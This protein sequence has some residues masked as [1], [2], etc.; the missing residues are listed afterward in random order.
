[1]L[2]YFVFLRRFVNRIDIECASTIINNVIIRKRFLY[3]SRVNRYTGWPKKGSQYHIM[4]K[5]Y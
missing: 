1:M 5:S 4:E 2:I 3:Y